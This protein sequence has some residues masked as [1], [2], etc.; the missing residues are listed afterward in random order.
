M[1]FT[2][3]HYKKDN[4]IIIEGDQ[5]ADCFFIIQQGQVGIS[6][7]AEEKG[8]TLGPG[9]YFGVI[10]TMSSH[11]HIETVQALTDVDLITVHREQYGAFIQ[12]HTQAAMKIVTQFSKQL[13]HLNETL[14]VIALKKTT[15]T[16]PDQLFEAAE[17]Y[18]RQNQ[19]DKAVHI[20]T[21][22]LKHCSQ[23]KNADTAKER[24]IKL[25]TNTTIKEME[26]R[27]S[28]M[29]RTYPK[30]SMLFVEGEPGD[31]LFVIQKG[32]VK[33]TKITSDNEVLLAVLKTG[34][35]FGEMA[36]LE[37]KPRAATAVAYDECK[38]LVLNR[39]NFEQMI[40]T[41][42]QLIAKVIALLA[43][44][45]WLIYK[46]L[47]NTL[48][49][50][51]LGRMYDSLLIQMEKDRIPLE[52]QNPYTFSFGYWELANMAGIPREEAKPILG[53]FLENNKIKIVDDKIYTA[54]VQ[55]I[56]RQTEYYR[57]M[58]KIR[59]VDK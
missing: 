43:D 28:D 50:N 2:T 18:L 15:E 21:L 3:V 37:N 25:K 45:L 6:R 39:V 34:D 27:S 48:I 47:A 32:S 5:N 29:S 35:I 30:N 46:Q 1:Q 19:Y 44:R 49:A 54:S 40:Q 7:E 31:E 38:V 9:D 22:Y 23:G 42:S 53:K 12:E 33:I 36:L 58:D 11:S 16:G 4:C 57:R 51:P 10:S 59:K 13:R 24:L 52:N 17:Y 56:V 26:F 55:E 14:A 41:Q 20:Y 8:R